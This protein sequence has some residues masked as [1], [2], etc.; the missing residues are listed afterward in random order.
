M[1]SAKIAEG[2]LSLAMKPAQ[3]AA[4]TGDLLESSRSRDG[5]WF[6]SNV[7]QAL[8]ATVWC[9]FKSQP[10]SVLWLGVQAW[11][12]KCFFDLFVV[13]AY[14]IV[15]GGV[16]HLANLHPLSSPTWISLMEMLGLLAAPYYTGRYIAQTSSGKDLAV[17][18]AMTS[19]GPATGTLFALGVG[20]LSTKHPQLESTSM[21]FAWGWHVVI[22]FALCLTGTALV[23]RRRQRCSVPAC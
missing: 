18:I 12:M 5:L 6:W 14:L 22:G 2:I 10:F 9:D 16:G 1:D 21:R 3:A 19:I 17:C 13:M 23:R 7:F 8:S 20:L 15:V 11:V 4:V